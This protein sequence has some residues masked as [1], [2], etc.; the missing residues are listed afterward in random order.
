MMSGSDQIP[1][2]HI[3]FPSVDQI[4]EHFGT[5][6]QTEPGLNYGVQVRNTAKHTHKKTVPGIFSVVKELRTLKIM[7]EI[8]LL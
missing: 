4:T 2:S 8:P 1:Y 5:D 3:L 7:L 6:K